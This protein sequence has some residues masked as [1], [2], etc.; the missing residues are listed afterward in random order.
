MHPVERVEVEVD[1]RGQGHDARRVH[2]D[3]DSAVRGLGGVVEGRHLGLVGHVGTE[4][5]GLSA[6]LG[7]RGDG[8]VGLGLVARVVH[9]DGVSLGGQT[10]GGLAADATGTS[11]DD[12]DAG[13]ALLTVETVGVGM[14]VCSLMALLLVAAGV[15]MLRP[16]TGT[17]LTLLR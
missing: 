15:A 6:G 1:E 8:L 14:P 3:V 16:P 9:D 2:D 10:L 11:G 17:T 5:D 7:D 12:R 13:E 4:G